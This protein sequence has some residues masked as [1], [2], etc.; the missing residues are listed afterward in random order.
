MSPGVQMIVGAAADFVGAL[1]TA[2]VAAMI[3]GGQVVVP[4]K[5]VWILG[6]ITGAMA[7]ASHVKASLTPAPPKG[8]G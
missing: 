4:S 7:A 5:G 1:G 6:V 8:G 2:T 3:Q